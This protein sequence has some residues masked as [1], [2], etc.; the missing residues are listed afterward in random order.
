MP[1]RRSVPRLLLCLAALALLAPAAS[2][3]GRSRGCGN[4]R[5]VPRHRNLS[6]VAHITLCLI[7]RQRT[8]HGLRPLHEN[9]RLDRAAG[10]HSADMVAHAYFSHGGLSGRVIRSGYRARRRLCALG[11][12]IAAGT[13]RFA[14][15]AAIVSMWMQSSGHRANILAHSYRDSGIGVAYGYPGAHGMRGATYT[16][17][18]ASRC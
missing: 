5:L 15:P 16:E 1:Q 4:T 17:E 10:A 3:P 2:A 18:F 8:A 12:N 14:T 9:A 6:Q 11:E 7:N 13:G